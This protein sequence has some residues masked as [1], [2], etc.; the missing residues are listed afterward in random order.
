MDQWIYMLAKASC[1]AALFVG[2]M[3]VLLDNRD[4]LRAFKNAH[5][6]I[7]ELDSSRVLKLYANAVVSIFFMFL[8]VLFLR[9]M[10]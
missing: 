8:A 1:W 7:Q 5:W 2:T 3:N 6:I 10:H 4:L 9:L